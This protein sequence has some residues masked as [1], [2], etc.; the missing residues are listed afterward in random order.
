MRNPRVTGHAVQ[1]SSMRS[2]AA[3]GDGIELE[4]CFSGL[5]N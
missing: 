5:R 2:N 4:Q 1:L 3:S